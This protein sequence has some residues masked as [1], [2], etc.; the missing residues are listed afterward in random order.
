MRLMMQVGL[1]DDSSDD[2]DN[3]KQVEWLVL[4]W[5]VYIFEY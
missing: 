1:D 5:S 2:E 3:G 4:N